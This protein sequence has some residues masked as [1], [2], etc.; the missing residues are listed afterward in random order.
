MF[1]GAVESSAIG[2]IPLQ[3]L[4]G[5]TLFGWNRVRWALLWGLGLLLFAHVIL[6]PVSSLV[7]TPSATGLWTV[8]LTVCVGDPGDPGAA[9][10]G[11]GGAGAA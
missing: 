1:I 9:G 10:D 3:F 2:L 7:P 8:L 11:S 4:S 5:S 6:Y